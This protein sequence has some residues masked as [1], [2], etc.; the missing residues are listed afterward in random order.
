MVSLV[1]VEGYASEIW[2]EHQHAVISMPDKRKGEKLVLV[3]TNPEAKKGDLS[4][5]AKKHGIVELSIPKIIHT[6][7]SIP[8]LPTGKVNY[9]EVASQVLSK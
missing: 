2:P 7:D 4:A 9:V 8:V 5:Y 1:A 6:I 3:T